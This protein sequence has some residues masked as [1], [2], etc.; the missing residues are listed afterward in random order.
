M[1][2]LNIPFGKRFVITKSNKKTIQNTDVII[3]AR[4]SHK[5]NTTGNSTGINVMIHVL[6][7]AQRVATDISFMAVRSSEGDTLP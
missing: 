3:T 4:E 6:Y 7:S 5:I 2:R 1:L